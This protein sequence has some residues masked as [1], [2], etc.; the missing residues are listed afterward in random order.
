MENSIHPSC[1]W[2]HL[3]Q[4]F[5]PANVKWCEERLCAF[6]NEPANAWSN[7]LFILVG[8]FIIYK[9]FKAKPSPLG[10]FNFIFGL[11]VTFMGTA[12]F[13]FHATNNYLTQIFDFIGMYFYIYFLF[14]LSLYHFK[15]ISVRTAINLFW[16][17]VTLS[18]ALIPA[19]RYIHFPYQAI[20]GFAAV[21]VAL[22]QIRGW[23]SDKNYPK[24]ELIFCLGFFILGAVFSY[25]DISRTV[26]HPENHFIQGHALW[27]LC[28]GFGCWFSYLVFSKQYQSS[29]TSS[30]HL[31]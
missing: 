12:S 10:K 19:S 31:R 21:T 2:S 17:C 5:G 7:L 27:H 18:T 8:L 4:S 30:D 22:L 16:G 29:S 24:K 6:I 25:L 14:C 1:P 28:C 20:V 11:I 23:V 3:E 15:K 13:V 26:C 9:G